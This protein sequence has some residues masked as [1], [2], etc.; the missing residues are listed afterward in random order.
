MDANEDLPVVDIE[1]AGLPPLLKKFSWTRAAP[2]KEERFHRAISDT[3]GN[4]YTPSANDLNA[5]SLNK[6]ANAGG[7]SDKSKR[8]RSASR[9]RAANTRDE[10]EIVESRPLT[11]QSRILHDYEPLDD[12]ETRAPEKIILD[13]YDLESINI[14]KCLSPEQRYW[15]YVKRGIPEDSIAP[16]DET[17]TEAVQ[18][19]IPESL[20]N[21]I[22]LKSKCTEMVEE[23]REEY[24]IALRQSIVNYILLDW[25]ERDR[26]K[27]PPL[28]A[29]YI[30]RIARAP[31][32]WHDELI[33]VKAQIAD[34][35]YVTN[36]V[37]LDLLQ[38]FSQIEGAR[39]IDMGVLAPSV[40]PM[41][42]EDF[43]LILRSQC[44][45]FKAKL[46]NEW[47][48]SVANMFFSSKDKWYTIATAAQDPD[49]GFRRLDSFFKS[50]SA[51]MSN[52]L[53]SLVE[54]SL[55]DFEK[56]FS[57]FAGASSDLSLFSVRLVIAGAQIRFEPPLS[58]LDSVIVS[59][60]EDMVGAAHEIPRIETKLFT[61]L[62]NE[63]LHLSA[64]SIDDD[65]I[66]E[67]RLVRSI[68]AKNTIAPQ[69]HLLSYDKYKS[70]LTH[71]AEKRIE[72]FLREKHD[73]DD[74][75]TEIKKL[76]KIVE[77]ISSSPSIVRFSMIYL[78]CEALKIELTS[79]ANALVQRLVDQVA[80]MNRK[81]NL[82]ICE[83]YEKISAKAM[84]LPAD[85]EEL[86]DL[87][88]YVDNAKMKDTVLLKEEITKGKKR[89]DFLLQYAFLTEED[90]KLNGVTFTWPS[91][92]LPIF[93]LAKKR[94]L[95]KK[96][97]A[98]DDLKLKI[99]STSDD[100]DDCFE[101][102]SKF[103][104][105]GIMSELPEYLKRI[106]KLEAKLAE[107]SDTIMQINV[108]E[109]LLEWEKTPFAKHQQTIE[110]LDPYKKLWE[111]ASNFQSEYSKWMNGPFSELN[112]ESVEET[113]GNMWRTVFKLTK[114]FN[115]QPV[116]RKVAEQVKNKL[117]KFKTHLPL[118][119]IL[120][121]PGLRE[122]H[123]KL[124][125]EIVGQ[126]I[127]P[128]ESTSLTKM[129][130]L[131]LTQHIQQFET[132]SDAASKEFSL[133]K[134]LSKMK[135]EWE[136]L[137]FNCID[138]KETGTKILSSLEEVQALLDDQIV[139]VQTMRGSPF[140]KPIEEEMP[141]EGKKFRS[142]DKTWRETMASTAENPKILVV[143]TVPGL[144]PRLNEANILLE[145]IQKGLNDYLEKKRLFFPRFFFLS[146]DEL[147]E[148][149]AETKDP[150]RVQP[151]LKKCFEG[152]A[153]L[154]FQDNSR[155][156]AMCSSENE[157]V[158]LKEV[159]EPAAAKGAVE[160]WLLQVEKVM[161]SSIH[162]QVSNGMKS[163]AET[164]RE[165][166]ILE[167][168]GQVV[169]CVSQIYWTRE[170]VEAIRSGGKHGL[171]EYKELC[172]RQ[173]DTTVSLVRGE[174]TPMARMTL[175]ALVVID[176]HA[177]DVV[178]ELEKAG[179]SN[180]NEFGWLSQLRY[181]WESDDV[182]V[183]MI[184]ATL[185]YGYEYL[186]NSAR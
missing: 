107:L 47:L 169:I 25:K 100:L 87:M 48:P 35:L 186:G 75:E 15:Y 34:S 58:D 14:A 41:S 125:E 131:N 4:N 101:Q 123:W 85:T 1:K 10:M 134:T 49:V 36:P 141:T 31:V 51:L 102:V 176:V 32:P 82:G 166:W 65:R 180:E 133:Q 76:L 179:I 104:D 173:L 109:E 57:Q 5:R 122:R 55:D 24:T 174:L 18:K 128:D 95:Q 3:I 183:R 178:A 86:V 181:Y 88:K 54:A 46:L 26:L 16:M 142:V 161:Q 154:T 137:V 167:W 69:K 70:L 96:V 130:D 155:I 121:N 44:Q 29:A 170:V 9:N 99:Q 138:Y 171:R 91:R 33:K 79:K 73:L 89:L 124:M 84:K 140:V 163:Y 78:D 74:Y 12:G 146:N 106:K 21:S 114:T 37:M 162:Q 63:T 81:I 20:L 61:S 59:V 152:I 165:K 90:I 147:L 117:D 145:E 45:A 143:G 177:R 60:L 156:I 153:S 135:D 71:K 66:A 136:P 43:Q 103:Q 6:R 115:D 149:L 160:K 108:E 11:P 92:I 158:R 28:P 168:P 144:L 182:Y 68:V 23:I 111:T 119:S 159:I 52:Q 157:R 139:K 118:I 64:M 27:I 110:L 19:H 13:P 42:I 129:L 50:V 116:P 148:I 53:W 132:I 113:V 83:S 93:E 112:G 97:K 80:D 72:E 184:N 105:Y 39:V 127:S 62:A 17:V 185:K 30:P 94:M 38:I 150:M 126:P 120:R 98:Q 22:S 77:E 67:G 7:E 40:D 175:S 172:T 2:F 151:H 56:F 8:P 164:P